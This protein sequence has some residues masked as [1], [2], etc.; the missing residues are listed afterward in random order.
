M[1]DP[2]DD[3]PSMEEAA[4][5]RFAHESEREF[6]AILDFYQIKWLYEP[7]MFP[8]RFDESGNPV[9]YFTPDFYLP[10]LDLFVELTTLKQSLVTRKNRKLRELRQLYPEI[11]IKLFYG[12]DFR[13]LMRKYGL[14][15][16]PKSGQ[17]APERG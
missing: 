9:E 7:R 4:S 6:A 8:L 17:P 3:G 2:T 5:P 15:T 13:R 10:E 16:G 12:R 11:N 1:D 14:A